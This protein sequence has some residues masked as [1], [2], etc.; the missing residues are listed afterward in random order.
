MMFSIWPWDRQRRCAVCTPPLSKQLLA[1]LPFPMVCAELPHRRY[2]SVILYTD[3]E[4]SACRTD[5]S[6]FQKSL[7]GFYQESGRAGRDGKD[8]DCV[9]YYRPQDAAHISAV[10]SS[11]KE[12]QTK[13]RSLSGHLI[14][15]L[16]ETCS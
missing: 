7:E 3:C 1:P 12:G 2:L 6:V 9:L 15:L 5:H 14:L 4:V 8:S 16:T 11:E 13:R 10:T